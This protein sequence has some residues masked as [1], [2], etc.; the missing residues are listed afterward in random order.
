MKIENVLFD[1]DSTLTTVEGID[2]LARWKGV[3]QE[4]V[5]LTDLA[6]DGRLDFT[7]ALEKRLELIMP[8]KPDLQRLAEIYLKNAV[9][10]AEEVIRYL[11]S[12]RVDVYVISGGFSP[13]VDVLAES[14]GI[15]RKNVFANTIRFDSKGDYAGFDRSLPTAQENG[16]ALVAKQIPGRKMMVGD[17]ISDAQVKPYVDLFVAFTGV[18]RRHAVLAEADVE[19]GYLRDLLSIVKG[20]FTAHKKRVKS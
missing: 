6:M 2:E 19:I 20:E 16:K 7:Q 9:D 12:E 13:A 11:K 3:H 17:G 8:S 18:K 4:V 1:C 14:L 10:G 5:D 15:D